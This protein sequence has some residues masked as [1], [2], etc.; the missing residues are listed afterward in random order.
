MPVRTT[1][2][3]ATLASAMLALSPGTA[4]AQPPAP[5]PAPAPALSVSIA[6]DTA[7]PASP[8]MGD[9]LSFHT[10]I[11]NIGAA[12]VQDVVGWLNVVQ[13]DAGQQQPVGLEDW[14]AQQAVAVARLDPGATIETDWPMRLI[15]PG[16]YRAVITAAAG[17]G[18]ALAASPLLD[19]AVRTKP[20]V[21]SARVLPVA[22]GIPFL[23]GGLLLVRLRRR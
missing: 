17:D 19:F 13:T 9:H 4:H 3:A 21:E 23:L 18:G 16:H 7:N 6:P 10:T 5:A 22:L 8:R 12:P 11:R 2:L 15:A 14:S 1:L 20:V